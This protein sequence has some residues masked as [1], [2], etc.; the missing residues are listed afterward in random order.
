LTVVA[1]QISDGNT[2][3]NGE[4]R[5]LW[6]NDQVKDSGRR[7]WGLN[8][9]QPEDDERDVDS[10]EQGETGEKREMERRATIHKGGKKRER[11]VAHVKAGRHSPWCRGIYLRICPCQ[12]GSDRTDRQARRGR[13]LQ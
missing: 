4:G 12:M 10:G 13:A 5:W 9:D 6:W 7:S 2:R 1:I 8:A 11:Q 3:E